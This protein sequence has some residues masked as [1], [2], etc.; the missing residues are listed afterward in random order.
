M[1][2]VLKNGSEP[3]RRPQESALSWYSPKTQIGQLWFF[4]LLN[5][6]LKF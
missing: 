2:K 3:Q 5:D 6:L 1:A 4:Q